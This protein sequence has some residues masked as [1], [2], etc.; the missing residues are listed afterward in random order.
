MK[1]TEYLM[2]KHPDVYGRLCSCHN[3]KADLR[4]LV[5]S[6]WAWMKSKGKDKEGF[7]KEDALVTILEW[8]DSN[9]QWQLC[10]LTRDEYDELKGEWT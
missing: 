5:N 4:V 2:E 7:T 8:L 9:N 1:W 3:T 10:D 6:R